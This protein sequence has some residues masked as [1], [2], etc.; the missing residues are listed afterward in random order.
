MV[1]CPLGYP[2]QLGP[3]RCRYLRCPGLCELGKL[4]SELPLLLAGSTHLGVLRVRYLC[5]AHDN[6][7]KRV[8]SRNHCSQSRERPRGP[9]ESAANSAA[10]GVAY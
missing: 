10:P 9:L 2:Q 4:G 5:G 6:R 3:Y 7:L 1:L 8:N